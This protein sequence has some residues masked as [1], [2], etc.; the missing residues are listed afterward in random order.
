MFVLTDAWK[1]AF[2]GA[3]AGLLMMDKVANPS[4]W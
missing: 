3:A 2:P 4:A 1:A